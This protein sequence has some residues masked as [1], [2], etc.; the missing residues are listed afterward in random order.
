MPTTITHSTGSI[1]PE[2]V[3]GYQATREARNVVHDIINRANPDVTLR[4][5]G[6]RRGGFRLLFTEQSDALAAYAVMSKPQVFTIANT[7]VPA[8]GMSF[9]V[10]PE[11]GAITIELNDT[12]TG[13]WIEVPFV[14]VI[15]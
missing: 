8:I 7:D 5:A 6:L 12:R 15:Q 10:G 1:N 4:A 14:E 11:G 9:V 3:D 2:S 13:W